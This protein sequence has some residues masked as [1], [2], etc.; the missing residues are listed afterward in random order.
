MP[1]LSVRFPSRRHESR[2]GRKTVSGGPI[3]FRRA[4]PPLVSCAFAEAFKGHA[5]ATE[6]R[7]VS[8]GRQHVFTGQAWV[9]V[10]HVLDAVARA[11]VPQHRLGRDARAANG[12]PP[13]TNFRVDHDAVSYGR[14][15]AEPLDSPVT[16]AFKLFF[17]G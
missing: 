12:G 2:A 16:G 3:H 5:V 15:L 13:I 8:Q 10:E 11:E 4:K 1:N 17:G 6:H 9:S 7:A 14:S